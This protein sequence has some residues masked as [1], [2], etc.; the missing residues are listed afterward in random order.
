MAMVDMTEGMKRNEED[1]YFP[2]LKPYKVY[3]D[4]TAIA[5]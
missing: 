3:E 2:I 1:K 4:V 5:L